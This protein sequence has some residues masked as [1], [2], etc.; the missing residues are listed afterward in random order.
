L[1]AV[2][3]ALAAHQTSNLAPGR[4]TLSLLAVL[5]APLIWV[6]AIALTGG[7]E[8][9]FLCIGPEE[10]HRVGLA[11]LAL[12]ATVGTVSWA[13]DTDVQRRFVVVA[14]PLAGALTLAARYVLRK[15]VHQLRKHG[16]YLHRTILVGQPQ[17]I[18]ELHRHLQRSQH[19]GYQVIGACLL[20]EGAATIGRLP[21]LGG[22]TDVASIVEASGA[23]TVAIEASSPLNGLDVRR[24][25]WE[26]AP[27]GASI[28]VAPAVVDVV[29]P[30]LA[31]GLS[32]GCR[33]STSSSRSSP[34]PSGPRSR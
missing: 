20:G 16:Q 1:S 2:L 4:P 31:I 6:T 13:T 19:H 32:R 10:F 28:L 8:R 23:D 34:A 25:S 7:Y 9:R 26:L 24:L 18:E 17:G 21:V 3:A 33:C 30:R 11:V 22:L 5:L 29:G 14:L 27:T 15:R 12:I